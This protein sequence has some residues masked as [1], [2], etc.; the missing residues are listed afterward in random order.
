MAP[1]HGHIKLPRLF[2][3]TPGHVRQTMQDLGYINRGYRIILAIDSHELFDYCFPVNPVYGRAQTNREQLG[4]SQAGLSHL[5][6]AEGRERQIIMLTPEYHDEVNSIIEAIRQTA[7]DAWDHVQTIDKLIKMGDLEDV[8]EQEQRA[9][10][11]IVRNSFQFLLTVMLGIHST[12][13]NR[14]KKIMD[15]VLITDVLEAIHPEDRNRFEPIW[16]RY[17]KKYYNTIYRILEEESHKRDQKTRQSNQRDAQA[18]DRLIQLNVEAEAA[19]KGNVLKH[20]YIFL[21]VSSAPRSERVFTHKDVRALLPRIYKR[22]S[23]S[24][25]RNRRQILAYMVY[26]SRSDKP[27]SER[28]LETRVEYRKLHQLLCRMERLRGRLESSTNKCHDCVLIGKKPAFCDHKQV[29]LDIQTHANMIEAKKNEVINWGLF[30]QV[31]SYSYLLESDMQ[32]LMRQNR[33]NFFQWYMA[34]FRD[35]LNSTTLKDMALERMR[36]RHIWITHASDWMVSRQPDLGG[37]SS[38]GLWTEQDAVRG[39]YQY[40]PTQPR[41]NSPLYEKVIE[42]VLQRFRNPYK[43]ELVE[44]IY[45]EFHS[46]DPELAQ[47]D[48]EYD[49]LCC[50]IY[51]IFP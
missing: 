51:L 4:E 24:F 46:L 3:L 48:D 22:R 42:L 10:D 34:V 18:I 19:F 33:G 32:G 39:I 12:G 40:L 27:L 26:H 6:E 11:D 15:N 28:V 43:K 17:R 47:K 2:G 38:P 45:E 35:L 44:Q 25:L 23:F 14:M 13:V 36:E 29:C 9:M 20:G 21:Y 8:S 5:F 1:T 37:S 7:P 31:T 49:L 41:F 16:N 30:D 50:Y